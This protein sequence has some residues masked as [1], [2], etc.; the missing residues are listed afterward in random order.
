MA[1]LLA[2]NDIVIA[3]YFGTQDESLDCLNVVEY[4]YTGGA[5]PDPGGTTV[6]EWAPKMATFWQAFWGPFVSHNFVWISTSVLHIL[7][8]SGIA[9]NR[10]KA[11]L[12][13]QWSDTSVTSAGGVA[14]DSLPAYCAYSIKKITSRPGRG[15]QGHVRIAGVVE[16]NTVDNRINTV[17]LAAI[18][19]ALA[20][21]LALS[22]DWGGGFTDRM[23]PVVINGKLINTTP[24]NPPV[25]YVD[26]IDG[27]A[28]QSFI[29]SQIT[30]KA[31]RKRRKLA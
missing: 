26:A 4:K 23:D 29:A 2:S 21:P 18:N 15:S 17:P 19:G 14:T 5:T 30:R 20:V 31:F 28:C 25:F 12:K 9:P 8:F 7:A 13:A 6:V 10:W 3:K 16:D 11:S 1:A 22:V 27:F 24:G